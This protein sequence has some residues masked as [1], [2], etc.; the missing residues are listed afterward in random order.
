MPYS[1]LYA[2]SMFNTSFVLEHNLSGEY[3]ADYSTFSCRNIEHSNIVKL[4]AYIESDC[5]ENPKI[6]MFERIRGDSLSELMYNKR[7]PLSTREMCT[8]AY[9]FYTSA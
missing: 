2:C 6:L 3:L 5:L 7:Q 4:L 1:L 9:D 8:T